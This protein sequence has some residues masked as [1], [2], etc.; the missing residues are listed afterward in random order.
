M[1][2]QPHAI[3]LPLKKVQLVGNNLNCDTPSSRP[4]PPLFPISVLDA[5]P[6]FCR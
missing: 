4:G 2:Y 1:A 3:Q 5:P 6:G